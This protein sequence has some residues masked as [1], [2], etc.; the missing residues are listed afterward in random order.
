MRKLITIGSFELKIIAYF[1]VLYLKFLKHNTTSKRGGSGTI[2]GRKPPHPT[3]RNCL[4]LSGI[5]GILFSVCSLL[6]TQLL[7]TFKA[8]KKLVQL[9]KTTWKQISIMQP[10]IDPRLN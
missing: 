8:Q 1:I 7:V 9:F 3:T 6:L 2:M 4:A 10:Y 5:L